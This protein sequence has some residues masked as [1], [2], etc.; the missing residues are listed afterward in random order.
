MMSTGWDPKSPSLLPAMVCYADILGFRDMTERALESGEEAEFLLR[1]KRSLAKA[2]DEVRKDQTLDGMVPPVF[3]MKVFTDNII[4][5]HPLRALA[6]DLGEPELGT[7]LTLFAQVQAGLAADGFFLRGAI[8]AGYHYQDQDV[9]YGE[10]LLEAVD[11]DKSGGA[12]RLVIGSSVEPLISNHLSWYGGG[13]SP[14]HMS[15][16]E[17]PQD[18]RLFV[19]Y[20]GVAFQHF[21]DGPIDCQLLAS[22]SENV[23]KGLQEHESNVSVRQKYEWIATYHNYVCRTFA[24]RYPVQG[25]EEAEP[26]EAAASVEAQCALEHL[27]AFDG[28]PFERLPLEKVPRPLDAQRLR[29]RLAGPAVSKEGRPRWLPKPY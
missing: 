14:H 2:Y 17:D 18:E 15:L 21:P 10:A 16:L 28:L 7:L 5:A 20:L 22:H 24:S 26:E 9:A 8:T 23:C 11:L 6:R 1:I 29:Q 27:V 25:Y 19:N 4:V 3:D 13:R 12:P